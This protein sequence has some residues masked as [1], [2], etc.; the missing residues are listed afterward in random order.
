MTCRAVP[1]WTEEQKRAARNA[2]HRALRN[3][4]LVRPDRCERCGTCPGPGN[5]D[6]HHASG[7]DDE[8]ATDVIWLCKRCHSRVHAHVIR[9]RA[10]G[11]ARGHYGARDVN[12][13]YVRV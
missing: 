11:K 5:I 13:R 12:G 1:M 10:G 9:A 2:V 8:H 4:D 7:Y 6:A 3:G